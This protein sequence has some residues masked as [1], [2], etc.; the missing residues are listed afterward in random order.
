MRGRVGLQTAKRRA[1]AA[2]ALI[3][4][5]GTKTFGIEE[6]TLS[7]RTATPR[8]AMQKNDRNTVRPPAF[9]ESNACV[10]PVTVS[11]PFRPLTDTE[12]VELVLAS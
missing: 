11:E 12:P 9:L 7:R 3:E 2:A 1:P 10:R 6:A 8:T 4:E 5:Q